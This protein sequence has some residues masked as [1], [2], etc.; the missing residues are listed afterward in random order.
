[1]QTELSTTAF[2]RKLEKI[3]SWSFFKR[4]SEGY[5]KPFAEAYAEGYTKGYAKGYAEGYVTG[6][7]EAVISL[8]RTIDPSILAEQLEISVADVLNIW[9]QS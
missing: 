3:Y 5:E 4:Y 6:V 1:M 8:K 9:E 7:K 2:E